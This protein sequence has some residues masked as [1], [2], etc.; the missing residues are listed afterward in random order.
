MSTAENPCPCGSGEDYTH[1]CE[2]YHKGAPTP[3]PVALM[4]SRYSAYALG[5][6]DYI[7]DTTHPKNPRYHPNRSEW[8]KEIDQFVGLTD[9][10]DLEVIAHSEKGD[11]GT[12]TFNAYLRQQGKDASFT[13]KSRF[14]KVDGRWLYLDGV[15]QRLA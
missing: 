7:I 13:E 4:R 3:H 2:P 10:V 5:L 1:C 14:E 6:S 9:F 12:V 15:P 8:K 11:Q